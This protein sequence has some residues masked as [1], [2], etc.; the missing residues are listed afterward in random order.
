MLTFETQG[1][2]FERGRQQA[3]AC[4]AVAHRWAERV[5]ARVRESLDAERVR[6]EVALM[7]R[8]MAEIYPEGYEECRGIAAGLGLEESDYFTAAGSLRLFRRLANCTVVGFRTLGG[9]PVIGKTD[10]ILWEELGSNV[11]EVT[12]P[13]RGYRHAHFHFAGSIWSVAGMNE[14]GLAMGMNGIAGPT[15]E[16][17]GL[18]SLEALHTILPACATVA[19]AVTHIRRLPLS[20]GGFSLTLGDAEGG[21]AVVERTAAGMAVLP[22]GPDGCFAHTNHILDPSFAA[23]NPPQKEPVGTNGRRRLCTALARLSRVPRSEE[24]MRSLLGD[25]S[26]AGAIFQTGEDGFH[27]DFAV[28]FAPVEKRLTCWDGHPER[29]EPRRLLMAELF[30]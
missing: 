25:A 15:L 27:T 20:H 13:D 6:E 16:R 28:I 14:R 29:S 23:R 7:C 30:A 9:R 5:R 18:A 19:E 11:L 26:P 17:P 21:L 24:G 1:P 12:R 8:E 4:E 3:F 2:P 10:D 22:S